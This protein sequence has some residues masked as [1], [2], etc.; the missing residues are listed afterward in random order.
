M[1]VLERLT[2]STEDLLVFRCPGCQENHFF[3]VRGSGTIWVWDGS[4]TFPTF[5]P[6]LLVNRDHPERRCHLF[7]RRGQ[8][9]FLHDCWHAL[10]G[11]TV[12]MEPV[13]P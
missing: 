13:A 9:E 10:K 6:S 5:T 7:V 1:D 2:N 4:M 12:P 11:K 8:I 3:R